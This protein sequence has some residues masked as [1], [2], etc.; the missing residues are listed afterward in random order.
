MDRFLDSRPLPV[1]SCLFFTPSIY[2]FNN[3]SLASNKLDK[4]SCFLGT[5]CI[6]CT[7]DIFEKMMVSMC[8]LTLQTWGTWE[9]IN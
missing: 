5:S 7:L 8:L 4:S 9:G 1:S 2:D 3:E 6:Q